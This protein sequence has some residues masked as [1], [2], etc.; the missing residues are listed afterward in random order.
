MLATAEILKWTGFVVGVLGILSLLLIGLAW[1][2]DAWCRHRAR[3]A[4][5]YEI[6]NPQAKPAAR[7]A[8]KP[9]LPEPGLTIRLRR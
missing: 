8:R 9:P 2:H 4:R 7:F 1:A 6:P 3:Y 5:G